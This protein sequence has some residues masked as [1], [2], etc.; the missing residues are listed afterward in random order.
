[1]IRLNRRTLCVVGAVTLAACDGGSGPEAALRPSYAMGADESHTIVVNPNAKGNGVAATIQEGI[2]RVAPGG[3][4]LVKPGTYDETL[5]IDKGLTLEAIGEGNGAVIIA[6]SATAANVVD[7]T[8]TEPVTIRDVTIQ[9]TGANGIRGFGTVDLTVENVSVSDL[10]PPGAGNLIAVF[11]D[12]TDPGRARV[13]VRHSVLDG[14]VNDG[15]PPLPQ[16][17]G[18]RVQGDVD[19][20]FEGNEIRRAGG[21]CI[22]VVTRGDLGGATNA[23]ILG[24][25]LDLCHPTGRVG[26]ILIGPIAGNL[27]SA[28][29]PV[30]ATGV[31]NIIGNVIHNSV[32]SC[33]P[34]T[35]IDFE[36][37]SGRIEHNEISRVVQP[38][39]V[40]TPRNLQGAIWLGR[41]QH[42]LFPAVNVS[43]R[44]NDIV[45]NA[46]AGLRIGP[47]QTIAIDASCNYWGAADGPSGIGSGS[48][49]AVVVE[50]GSASTGPGGAAPVF[51]PFAAA[52]IAN[53]A[54][55]SCD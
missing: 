55:T 47:N 34:G 11:D 7:V 33:L 26:S 18:L 23:D 29:R 12:E 53:T 25:Q 2:N 43:V 52:P 36:V 41:R 27:P 40:P 4:V 20:V 19:A 44:F 30:T 21:A 6:P 8:T 46:F 13:A 24:N 15:T 45:G 51:V 5:V 49:D 32:G 1:M 54:A 35:A 31:V 16:V 38:C 22:F 28:D 50:A 3:Q 17:F 10:N 48:G 14:G 39:A 37:G 42:P 9:Y